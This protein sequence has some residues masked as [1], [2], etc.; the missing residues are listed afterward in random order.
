F[1]P[2]RLYPWLGVA[3]GLL[4]VGIGVNLLRRARRREPVHT[5]EPEP[6]RE[7]V[8]VGGGGHAH[9]HSHPHPHPHP[10]PHS[11]DH[12]D[13]PAELSRRNLLAMGLAGGMVPTP[14]ALVVLLGAIALGRAWFGVVLVVAYGVGMAATL[15][16]AG[17]LLVRARAAIERRMG[18]RHPG[19]LARLSTTLPVV[20]ASVIMAAG[21]FLAVRGAVQ[22]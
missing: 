9:E 11:H 10:H 4:V 2:E 6:V 17:L 20:S 18:H 21:L 19:R 5:H 8:T 7:L 14:S 1:T 16:G 22:L 13:R 12:A 3:S 15:T